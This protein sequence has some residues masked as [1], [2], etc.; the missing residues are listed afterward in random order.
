MLFPAAVTDLNVGEKLSVV[1]ESE[2][3]VVL[4]LVEWKRLNKLKASAGNS[5]F[6]VS[7]NLILRET[8]KSIFT[9]F[10]A[11]NAFRS[12][13]GSLLEPPAPRRPAPDPWAPV[14]ELVVTPE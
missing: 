9:T 13:P 6:M 1:P 10:G 8:R 4:M 11:R 7:V 2:Y 3:M 5:R 12:I 14:K